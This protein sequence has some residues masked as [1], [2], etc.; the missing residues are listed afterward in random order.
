MSQISRRRSERRELGFSDPQG[1]VFNFAL[2]LP[3]RASSPHT[4]RAYFRWVDTYLVDVA[5]LKPTQAEQRIQRMH[6]LPVR[7]LLEVLSP[8]QLR[9]WLGMLAQRGHGRQGI[10]QARAAIVT[11]ADLLAEAEWLDDYTAAAMARVRAP[12]AEDGQ[13]P[14]R[15]LSTGQLRLLMTAAREIAT[16]EAQAVRNDVVVTTLCTMALRREELSAARWG[17]LSLQN[18]RAVLRVHGKG[19]KVAIIDVPRP[20]LRALNR[21]R[22]LVT[23]GQLHPL[24]ES[25]LVRRIWKGGRV[26]RLGLSPDGMWLIVDQAAAF[27][28]LGHVAPHDL[29]RSVAGALYEANVP[30]DKISRLLRHSSIAITERY[31]QRLPQANEGAVLMSDVLQLDDDLWEWPGFD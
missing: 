13:R 9:A 1:L 2:T 17:D 30:V 6:T 10:E 24:P 4:Q 25:A 22:R 8:Q 31:L 28:G 16:S 23:P 12:R 18:D 15:W 14:G 3:G 7:L 29:R 21:W 26:A 27:A 5:G 11:L 20:V 19:R